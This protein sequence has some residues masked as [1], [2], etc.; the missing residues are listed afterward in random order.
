MIESEITGPVE[1]SEALGDKLAQELLSKGADKI[2]QQV[3]SENDI[4]NS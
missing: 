1:E 2:L 4:K 3:Y